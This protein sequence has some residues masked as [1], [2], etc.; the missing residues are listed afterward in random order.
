MEKKTIGKFIAVLR[1]ANGM[2]QKDLGERL[3]VSDK[4]VSRWERDECEPELSLLPALAEI[5]GITTDEL[6]RGERNASGTETV[7]TKAKSEKQF[8]AMLRGRMRKYR[9]LSV[10][11]VGLTVLG[12]LAAALCNLAFAKGALAFCI[13]LAFFAAG[14]LCQFVFASSARMEDDGDE[15]HTQKLAQFNASVTKASL[16]LYGAIL[17]SAAFCLPLVTLIDGTNFGMTFGAWVGYGALFAAV[18]VGGVYILAVLF[19]QKPSLA[20]SKKLL[21]RCLLGVCIVSLLLGGGILFLNAKGLE[22]FL[23]T[24]TFE[25]ANELKAYLEADYDE[26]NS[27]NDKE[28]AEQYPYREWLT[29]RGEDGAYLAS[30][31][32]NPELYH[33]LE[34]ANGD[35]SKLPVTV[36]TKD[37]YSHAHEVF[38]NLESALYDA[39]AV[40]VAVWAAVYLIRLRKKKGNV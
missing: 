4:T 24:Q 6:L 14:A 28:V 16:I 17:A 36:V 19:S 15:A 40:N 3:F 39:L 35:E 29:F 38:G 21:I 30:C 12:L 11:S 37:S 33:V 25:D 23:K 2:T 1:K 31:Y 26:W 20:R 18:A 5:F 10:L 8:A 27:H 9:N 13:S 7:Q 32:Y 22:L 34:F